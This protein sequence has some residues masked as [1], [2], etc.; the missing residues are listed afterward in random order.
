M[1]WHRALKPIGPHFSQ[2]KDGAGADQP[3]RR[4]RRKVGG[5][6][7]AMISK[8]SSLLVPLSGPAEVSTFRQGGAALSRRR[9]VP[10]RCHVVCISH[11]VCAVFLC[12]SNAH[13]VLSPG[14]IRFRAERAFC[15]WRLA[16]RGQCWCLVTGGGSIRC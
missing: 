6:L 9:Q 2:G 14:R 1:A 15:R 11:C 10:A 7:H 12:H 3:R 8:T 13:F 4:R 5:S 16:A